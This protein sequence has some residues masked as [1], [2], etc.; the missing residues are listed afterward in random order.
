MSTL[1]AKSV[2]C[3][4]LIGRES[5]FTHLSYLIDEVVEGSG[6]VALISGEAGIGKSRLVAEVRTR[7]LQFGQGGHRPGGALA[8]QGRCFEPDRALPYAPIVDLLRAL[9]TLCTPDE[10]AAHLG[11]AGPEVLKLLPE[12]A[13]IVPGLAPTPSLEPEMEKRRLYMALTQVF[14]RLAA[15]QPLMLIIEDMHWSDE[16]SLEFL[17]GLAR[18]VSTLTVL[19]LFTYRNDET[20][21]AL[22]N[23]VA[24]LNRERLATELSLNRLTRDEVDV[25]VQAILGLR[26][27]A[28]PD[29]LSSVYA[30]TEGN[31]FF[32]EEVLKSLVASGDITYTHGGWDL[33]PVSELHIPRSAQV[34][35]QQRI[36]SISPTARQVL[37]IAAVAGRRFDFDLLQQL[38]GLGEAELL[39]TIKEL[40][41]AQ[42]VVEE[43]ADKKPALS[44]GLTQ[45]FAFR[46]ALT[47]QAMYHD[48]LARERRLLHRQIAE[49]TE[50]IHG[51]SLDA[52]LGDLA[53]HC[54]EGQVWEHALEYAQRA[55]ER[56]TSLHS[57]HAAVEH[58]TRAVEAARQLS[59]LPPLRLL[60]LLKARA[61]AYEL[62]GDFEGAR[63]DYTLMLEAARQAHDYRAEWEALLDLGWLWTVRDYACAG[64]YIAQAVELVGKMGDLTTLAH[65]LNRTGNWYAH[66]EEPLKAREA[67]QEALRIFEDSGDRQGV[68]ATLDLLGITSYMAGDV[69]GG[70]RYYERAVPVFR[71]L[72]D[73]QGLVNS[74]A[75]LGLR[76]ASFMLGVCVCPT[77]SLELCMRDGE[78]AITVARRLGWQ[79]GEGMALGY[80]AHAL[81]MRGEYGEARGLSRQ[82][83]Q[84]TRE[85]EHR[86]WLVNA[87]FAL[88]GAYLDLLAL[89]QAREHLEEATE[90]AKEI[91]SPFVMRVATS[92]L[93]STYIAQR[94]PGL[95]RSALSEVLSPDT[96]M[97]TLAQ[98]LVW[99]S[100]A[101][102]ELAARNPAEAL[103]ILDQLIASTPNTE[104]GHGVVPRLWHL[105]GQAMSALGRPGEAEVIFKAAQET[106]EKQDVKPI[107]WRIHI[108]LGKLLRTRGRREEAEAHFAAAR[109][110]IAELAGKVPDSELRDNFVS[111]ALA[112]MPGAPAPSLL[113]A[114]KAQYG[115]L[116]TREREVAIGIA[117][118]KSNSAIGGELV[119]SERTVEKHVENIMSKLGFASRAQVAAW[120]VERGLLSSL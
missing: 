64:E 107:L 60:K 13:S 116:T 48:L 81:G 72:G 77:V 84:V 68:A 63:D 56:D 87:L 12:L 117:Q 74:L 70:V 89:P 7:F 69:L 120:A 97:R 67:H 100:Y 52:H 106:A 36:S 15:S 102:L 46:H 105:R 65:T 4:L 98:Q 43:S 22:D 114:A 88:G 1:F 8:L 49:A 78:E 28:D 33:K 2:V 62:L 83:I 5:A 108:S 31:P 90:L 35:V 109:E 73:L 6:Q 93:A 9:F 17:L 16:A 3:P 96:P 25:M 110:I 94:Q 57:P 58:Y 44:V 86:Q 103:R 26:Y 95:A 41:K 119:L 14:N 30:L 55:G 11:P 38:T 85:I 10:V 27:P 79:A 91:G 104:D 112:M 54:Y 115:G 51:S 59:L 113:R 20:H 101:E 29:F 118:G 21:P 82:A 50:R 71:E 19:L 39:Q 45:G 18:Q 47:R 37:G 92:F 42:L 32:L 66:T 24:A 23:F 53:Y 99:G 76:G 40:I 75:A 111:Q 80:M 34:A 61:Q